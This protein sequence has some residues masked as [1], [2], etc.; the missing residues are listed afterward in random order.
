[1]Q[2]IL[3]SWLQFGQTGGVV[4]SAN[5]L[6]TEIRTGAEINDGVCKGAPL[7]PSKFYNVFQLGHGFSINIY[8]LNFT[9]PRPFSNKM[10]CIITD[11]CED[12]GNTIFLILPEGSRDVIDK[13][14]IFKSLKQRMEVIIRPIGIGFSLDQR[15]QNNWETEIN[16]WRGGDEL[17]VYPIK[18]SANVWI[19]GE[20]SLAYGYLRAEG[21]ADAHVA[22]PNLQM[23]LPSIFAGEW[24]LGVHFTA[25][26]SLQLNFDFFG[27]NIN[28]NL[29]PSNGEVL[30]YGS[31]GGID[32]RTWCGASANPPGLF[33]NALISI[34]AFRDIPLLN[35]INID[36]RVRAHA[37]F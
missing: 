37:F 22:V 5:E 4:L 29:L 9:I 23:I 20:A 3:P 2:D 26:A 33:L 35:F 7:N 28:I 13:L 8:G 6:Q 21:R 14:S 30:L 32:S 31:L 34:N 27:D 1:M 15:I 17:F 16:F 10:Y 24:R 12:L 25:T 19:E 11:I 36:L 18:Q